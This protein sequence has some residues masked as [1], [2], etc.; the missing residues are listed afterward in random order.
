MTT[1]VNNP[2]PSSDG[3]GSN[4]LIGVIVLLVVVI[5]GIYFVLPLLQNAQPTQITVPAP[6]INLPD[7]IDVNVQE[8][9]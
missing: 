7:K 4:L 9:K 8:A 2:T 5:L 3:G 1:I 6:Q